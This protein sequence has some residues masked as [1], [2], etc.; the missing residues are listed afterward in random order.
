MTMSSKLYDTMTGKV[1]Y[2]ERAKM[3]KVRIKDLVNRELPID[4][5]GYYPKVA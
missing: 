4:T 3:A 5:K 2:S 1:S